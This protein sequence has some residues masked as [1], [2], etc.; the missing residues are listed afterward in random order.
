[1]LSN[2][3]KKKTLRLEQLENREL[4]S[5][6][7]WENA[8]QADAVVAAEMAS[9][10]AETAIDLSTI[11]VDTNSDVMADD[12]LTTLREAI[13]AAQDGDT[14]VFADGVK[15]IVLA[16]DWWDNVLTVNQSIT[17]DGGDGVTIDASGAQGDY[18]SSVF[19]IV[20][21]TEDAP[22]TLRGLTITGG[23]AD[24]GGGVYVESGYLVVED[25]TITGNNA[26]NG[27]GVYVYR[28]S[29]AFDNVE[30]SDNKTTAQYGSGGDGA[31]IFVNHQF[32]STATFDACL[33]VDNDAEGRGAVA[34]IRSG[35]TI[36]I[37]NTTIAGNDSAKGAALYAG[38]STVAVEN[39]IIA[40]NTIAGVASSSA[41]VFGSVTATNTLSS[42]EGWTNVATAKNYVYNATAPLF[43]NATEGDYSLAVGSQALVEGGALGSI[44]SEYEVPS[45]VVTIATDVVDPT[46]GDISLREA[47]QYAQN[48]DTIKFDAALYNE[49]TGQIELS[50]TQGQIDVAKTVTVDAL[51][52]F[53]FE[54]LE[55][56]V[57]NQDATG[58]AINVEVASGTSSRAFEIKDGGNLTMIGVTVSGASLVGSA[59]EYHGGAYHVLAG[60]SLT[61]EGC[62]VENSHAQS[63]GGGI[64]V[65]GTLTLSNTIVQNCDGGTDNGGGVWV[66]NGTATVRD[67]FIRNNQID[68]SNGLYAGGG[69]GVAVDGGTYNSYNTTYAH[70]DAWFGAGLFFS[71]EANVLM[72]NDVVVDNGT[73]ANVSIFTRSGTNEGGGINIDGANVTLVNCTVAD[74]GASTGGGIF[75][76]TDAGVDSELT[77]VN[78]IVVENES[79]DWWGNVVESDIHVESGSAATT[80]NGYNSL[81]TFEKWDN[82]DGADTNILYDS[83]IQLFTDIEN[84]DITLAD[85]DN[86]A[87]D[88]G[89]LELAVQYAGAENVLR[90]YQ[91]NYR[92]NEGG[93]LDL[94]GV[95]RGSTPYYA[96]AAP[97]E[98]AFS[99][100]D[101][102][103][104]TVVLSWAD[105]N[106][107]TRAF[108]VE[109][110]TDGGS[111]W[112]FAGEA[113]A[114]NPSLT[115]NVD[116]ETSYI[117][118]V[119][120]EKTISEVSAWTNAAWEPEEAPSTVVTTADDVV[121]ATD[122]EISLREALQ[123]AAAGDT[124]TFADGVASLKLNGEIL[125][126]KA[127]TIDGG[128]VLT[129]D[130]QGASRVFDVVAGTADAPVAF[131][132]LT[133]T[134]GY[135]SHGA[136][137]YVS[138]A[139]TFGNVVFKGNTA[140]VDGGGVYVAT[141][142]SARL[143]DVDVYQNNAKF[144]AG[145]YVYG[146]ATLTRVEITEN[147]ASDRAGGLN[148]SPGGVVEAV[149]VTISVNQA[150]SAAGVWV[151]SAA[152]ATFTV[153]EISGNE[154][155]GS[156]GGVTSSTAVR[157]RWKTRR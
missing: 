115:L 33:I 8:A 47:F 60:G 125:V 131:N 44:A 118:R 16:Q 87:I 127:I 39:S 50:L 31:A 149:D 85:N 26:K 97:T 69:G 54:K 29:V 99:A 17:I 7:T 42:Y 98:L 108:R 155:T 78:T 36:E 147:V 34:A 88:A 89:N 62:V 112:T 101:S 124:I 65:A 86:Q 109:V 23:D 83:E 154:A 12:G 153:G 11:V 75:V 68:A 111:T 3:L 114:A 94:G 137:V 122:G 139:A 48:G 80:V 135:A 119:R 63:G 150:K 64:A 58:V 19:R 27:G 133:I 102:E 59:D 144:G 22:V 6:T 55:N 67:S 35:A 126:D 107:N 73:H 57:H 76:N 141:G 90:D 143:T 52:F 61:L 72:V 117:F 28:G 132:G 140:T 13:A 148:V 96:L 14:I 40:E 56:N 20:G 25:S 146:N 116:A 120:A 134:G 18:G 79:S 138:G 70:N 51:E 21:G 5:A 105:S 123:Y 32:A 128:G 46:D 103:A 74:N 10:L 113:L 1:M 136:G 66:N 121:D 15:N 37:A 142:G 2:V 53:H 106:A 95:E 49:T 9:T 91:N 130:A 100:Y 30:I 145:V 104:G 41:D 93:A 84:H 45:L 77:L 43:E 82:A 157:R 4:L 92:V 151:G 81:T 129:V 156:G 110:S 152:S 71:D 24:N 38:T